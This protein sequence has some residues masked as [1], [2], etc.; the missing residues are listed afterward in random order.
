MIIDCDSRMSWRDVLYRSKARICCMVRFH[1]LM[2]AIDAAG[3]VLECGD[4]E[5]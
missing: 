4:S 2:S 3:G 5:S 1:R